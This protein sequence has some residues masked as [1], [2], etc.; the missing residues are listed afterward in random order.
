M[1]GIDNKCNTVSATADDHEMCLMYC[2]NERWSHPKQVAVPASCLEGR[3][4]GV[5]CSLYLTA[6]ISLHGSHGRPRARPLDRF[7][8][9]AYLSYIR[10]VELHPH[11]PGRR[12]AQVRSRSGERFGERHLKNAS[13]GAEVEQ[14][15]HTI[16][17]QKLPALI[18][19]NDHAFERPGACRPVYSYVIGT[20]CL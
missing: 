13:I 18:S 12:P 14:H 5:R 11:D 6:A 3:G 7:A 17:I 15:A 4:H 10:T 16:L 20:A 19:P 8:S 2:L 9:M 1:D